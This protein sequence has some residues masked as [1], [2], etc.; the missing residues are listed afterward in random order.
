MK[1]TPKL[2]NP[3]GY[4]SASQISLFKRSPEKYIQQY[5]HGES[6]FQ[7]NRME[8][9][10]KVAL[11]METE[12]SD[13]ELINMAMKLIP[14]YP[15]TEY[16]IRVPFKSQYGEVILL[17]KLDS[18]DPIGKR[19]RDLKTGTSKWT[20]GRANKLE[21]LTHYASIIWLKYKKFP[22][23]IWLDWAETEENEGEITLTG[24]IESFKVKKSVKDILVYFASVGK[25]AKQINDLYLLEL[26]KLT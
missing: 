4:L 10:S 9:G 24:H 2:L 21:Q 15:K 8:F 18:F 6:G 23:E 16:E 20:Q 25:V 26:K 17:G 12:E 7:N 19:F 3:R 11:A 1:S 22:A 13:D 14:R 5:V